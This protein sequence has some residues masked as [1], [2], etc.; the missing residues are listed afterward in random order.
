MSGALVLLRHG[1]SEWNRDDR[2]AG[3][4]DI[5][6]TARGQDQARAAGAS[7]REAGIRPDIV[8]TSRLHRAMRTAELVI[9]AFAPPDL[10]VGS[11]WRLNERHYGALQGRTRSSVRD[12]LGDREFMRIRRSLH[13]R[14]P[15]RGSGAD[16]PEPGATPGQPATVEPM[17]ESLDDVRTRLL[18]YWFVN[19][20]PDLAAG[21]T[22]LIAAHGNT[23]R[24][25]RW[26]LEG[27]SE[28]EVATLRI[29]LG[30]PLIYRVDQDTATSDGTATLTGPV[31]VGTPGPA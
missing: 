3:W 18:P 13:G 15:P 8:H 22:V 11:S 21:R 31:L 4:C 29:P 25:L 17:A 20:R 26:H 24:V 14:P 27:L 7:L 1:E 28:A 6:L 19:V 2:F 9:A 16:S 23:I 12:E 10:P 5:P 30:T